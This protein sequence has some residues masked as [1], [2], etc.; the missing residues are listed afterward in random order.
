M[1]IDAELTFHILHHGARRLAEDDLGALAELGFSIEDMYSIETLTLK[2]LVHLGRLGGR[3]LDIKIDPQRFGRALAH[4]QREADNEKLQETLLRLRAPG[5]MMRVLFG[6]TPLQYANRRKRLG[7]FGA[8]VGRPAVPTEA[9]ERAIRAAWQQNAHLPDGERYLAT[10]RATRSLL[11]VVWPV[12]R[13]HE[14]DNIPS[15]ADSPTRGGDATD[16]RQ[17]KIGNPSLEGGEPR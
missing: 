13:V 10:A 11:S 8:G 5:T 12:V 6:M 7:L 1:N 3:F 16:T 2:D 17:G 15:P 4:V 9:T 14:S